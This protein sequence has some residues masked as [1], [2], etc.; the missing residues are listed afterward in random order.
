MTFI[1]T[2][3]YEIEK[4]AAPNLPLAPDEWD[5][6]FQDQ[7]SNVLRLYFNRLDNF[8]A[9]LSASGTGGV[10]GFPHISASS[11][12][13]QYATGN[14]TPTLVGFNTLETNSGFT[15][16]LSGTST[17]QFSGVYRIAYGLQIANTDNAIHFATVWLRVNAVDVPLSGVKFSLPARKNPAEPFEVLAFS[18]IV[19][20]VNAGDEIALWWATGQAATSGGALGLYLQAEPIQTTPYPHPSVPSAIGSITFVSALST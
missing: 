20:S 9:R 19:F 4:V 16:N 11:N 15:L 1:V 17:C 8:M 5:R 2:T 3:N 14:D 12:V 7:Y 13:S 10:V 6:R 18:E